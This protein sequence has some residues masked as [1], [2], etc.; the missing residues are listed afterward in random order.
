MSKRAAPTEPAAPPASK[1]VKLSKVDHQASYLREPIQPVNGAMAM[2]LSNGVQSGEFPHDALYLAIN[3]DFV[4]RMT[5]IAETCYQAC[6][7]E[8]FRAAVLEYLEARSNTNVEVEHKSNTQDGREATIKAWDERFVGDS[9]DVLRKTILYHT[10]NV[11][12]L[13]ARYIPIVQPP[14]SAF[15][16]LNTRSKATGFPPRDLDVTNFLTTY[17]TEQ[18][19]RKRCHWFMVALFETLRE[20]ITD[21]DNKIDINTIQP[22]GEQPQNIAQKLRY[23]MTHGQSFKEQGPLR[24]AFYD[25]VVGK[26]LHY[27]D[28]QAKMDDYHL[29]ETAELLKGEISKDLPLVIACDEVHRLAEPLDDGPDVAPF[30]PRWTFLHLLRQQLSVIVRCRHIV[31]VF[32]STASQIQ[33]FTPPSVLDPSARLLPR[34]FRLLPPFTALGFDQLA[35]R[36]VGPG[37]VH[38]EDIVKDGFICRFGR[39]L[40]GT[41]YKHGSTLDKDTIVEF[42]AEKLL[43]GAVPMNGKISSSGELACLANR[44]ALSLT[45]QEVQLEQVANHMRM[46]ITVKDGNQTAVTVAASEP[47]LAEASQLIT[48]R[49]QKNLPQLL[50]D[51]LEGPSL[52]LGDR[53]EPV[54][55]LLLT[56]ARDKAVATAPTEIALPTHVRKPEEDIPFADAFPFAQLHFNHFIRVTD[57]KVINRRYL[58]RAFARGAAILCAPHQTGIDAL[59][60]ALIDWR[61]PLA[62]DNIMAIPIQIM[63]DQPFGP[64]PWTSLF[65]IMDPYDLGIYDGDAPP[66]IRV[67]FALASLLPGTTILQGPPRESA[68][69]MPVGEG[70]EEQEPTRQSRRLMKKEEEG[71][72]QEQEAL[73]KQKRTGEE[74]RQEEKAKMPPKEPAK[75]KGKQ[76]Q[77]ENIKTPHEKFTSYDIWCAGASSKT[78]AVIDSADDSVFAS[79]LRLDSA[80]SRYEPLSCEPPHA[81]AVKRHMHPASCVGDDHWVFWGPA[82]EPGQDEDFDD[83][84]GYVADSDTI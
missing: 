11:E 19:A 79:L 65:D 21:I 2:V 28:S 68:H 51:A 50:K 38:I 43:G 84:H 33:S 8:E 26:A 75:G 54:A 5:P 39:P 20:Y 64:E 59:L 23:L 4:K 36:M 55:L 44:L 76:L 34:G 48:S 72:E 13:Y 35:R 24:I 40:F 18:M 49:L 53:G 29:Y 17:K 12:S 63:R 46:F 66:S 78:F 62:P 37:K 58:C 14:Q 32:L 9:A 56:M 22:A 61:E 41:R 60:I 69:L 77:D 71:Q 7:W 3:A 27:C 52:D 25:L 57:F 70:E 80:A 81:G 82:D 15:S 30:A 1:R 45:A 83:E 67:V 47:I 6:D 16:I 42:A 74:Q 31:T 10:S 73:Q